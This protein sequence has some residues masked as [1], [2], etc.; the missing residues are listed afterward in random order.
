MKNNLFFLIGLICSS[1]VHAQGSLESDALYQTPHFS[2]HNNMWMNLHHFFYEKAS[3]RQKNKLKED[4]LKFNEIGD[5]L[6]ITQLT[7]EEKKL[8][9]E[10]VK[11]YKNSIIDQRLLNSGRIF[12]WL[13]ACPIQQKITDTTYSK[14][15]T[16]TLNRLKPLYATHFW[17]RHQRENNRLLGNYIKWIKKTES[18]VIRQM[19]MLSGSKW[20][21]VVRIDLTTY[22][23]WA[24]AY[25]P[26]IDNIVV[27]SIDPQ[28]NSTLFVEFVFH[29]SSHL[30][31][32]RK[33]PFRMAIFKK[34][35]ELKIK[36][37]RQ[38]WHASMFYLSGLATKDALNE[39][40]VGHELI[41]KKKNVFEKYYNN[42]QFRSI[43]KKYYNQEIELE[44]MAE[45][46]LKLK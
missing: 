37:P 43:L 21:G 35:K 20:K 12:K 1:I 36:G 46:L 44:E 41:M 29:E 42:K 15:F 3:N 14:A 11:F 33:S 39:N 9:D 22:G 2:F 10:G 19:E 45:R 34:S 24:G 8:F 25:S 27:S 17:E 32:L 38:L 4:D 6:A 23:N 30:L 16:T 18:H 31:F 26:D 28:M 40:G 13:Q 7:P 5:S